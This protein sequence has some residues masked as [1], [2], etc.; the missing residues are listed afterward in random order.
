MEQGSLDLASPPQTGGK[1]LVSLD[2]LRG[3]LAKR[4]GVRI[5]NDDPALMLITAMEVIARRMVAKF[6]LACERANDETS[7][8]VAQQAEASKKIAEAYVEGAVDYMANQLKD[9]VASLAPELAG[10]TRTLLTQLL[11]E[12]G[13]ARD[14]IKRSRNVAVVG[15]AVSVLVA[16]VLVAFAVGRATVGS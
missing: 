1:F 5:R 2:D 4:H 16:V 8:A 7:A 10:E 6:E 12:C 13:E 15:A 3:E 9:Q 14:T 11:R